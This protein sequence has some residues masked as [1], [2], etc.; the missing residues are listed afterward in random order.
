MLMMTKENTL[1]N[2][3]PMGQNLPV[4]NCVFFDKN[5]SGLTEPS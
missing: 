2:N 4:I 3:Y 5:H 1:K